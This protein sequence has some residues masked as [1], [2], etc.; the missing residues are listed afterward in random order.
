MNAVEK[1]M[2]SAEHP[3]TYPRRILLTACGLTPQIVT[4]TLYALAVVRRP[5]FVPTEVHVLTT[6]EGA[7]RLRLQLLSEEPGWF[8]RFCRDYGLEGKI[9]LE[10]STIHVLVGPSGEPL[11]DIRTVEENELSANQIT[12]LVRELTSEEDASLHV[13]IAG[14]R[15]TMGFYLGYA[16]SLFGRPQDRMSHVLVS[17]PYES[18]PLFFYP[19][20]RSHVIYAG[21][22]DHRPLDTA[23]AEVTLAEIPFVRLRHGLPVALLEGRT[24]FLEVVRAAQQAVGPP[25]L[26]IDLRARQIEAAGRQVSLPPAELAF[27]SWFARRK[28]EGRP[29][30]ACPNEGVPEQAYAREFLV[31]YARIVEDYDPMGVTP[32]TLGGGMDKAYFLQRRS[33]LHRIL[34]QHLGPRAEDY[35]IATIGRRPE[36]RYELKLE[37]SQIHFSSRS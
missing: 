24:G 32:K 8:W 26:K 37:A 7:Q 22:P 30:L 6:A 13:S 29:P 2:F 18:N 25:E 27:L 5:A 3:H 17:A 14:G 20:P 33:K 1:A 9:R 19:T 11:S 16:L 28:K 12:E 31:E 15:K 35:F 36:T 4:E 23:Q 10:E 21:P 34:K